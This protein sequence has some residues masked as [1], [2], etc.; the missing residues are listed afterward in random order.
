MTYLHG[1]LY[2]RVYEWNSTFEAYV[3]AGLAEFVLCHDPAWEQIWLAER[4]EEIIGA[5]N[6][7]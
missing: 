6:Q 5:I 7:R 2:A 3:A 4:D 1:I